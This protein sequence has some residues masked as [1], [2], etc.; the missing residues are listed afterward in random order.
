MNSPG[1]SLLNMVRTDPKTLTVYFG[2]AKGRKIRANYLAMTRKILLDGQETL[3]PVM[4][5]LN[6]ESESYT[7]QEPRGLLFSTQFAQPAITLMNL[8]EMASLKSRGL[9][10][11]DSLFAGHSLGEYSA[12]AACSG[13]MSLESLLSLVFYRGLMMQM[14]MERDTFGRTDF[15]MVA[16]NPS[17]VGKSTC[18][19][20]LNLIDTKHCS[21]FHGRVS[22]ASCGA[23]RVNHWATT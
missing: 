10:Q 5:G 2:G 22:K 20:P 17:R 8:A 11:Q 15:S 12:L 13:F 14:A 3:I 18:A 19:H 23:Y 1:F 7:F 4:D 16:V 9:V 21:R 6:L